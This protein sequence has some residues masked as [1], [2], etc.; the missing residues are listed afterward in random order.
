MADII[1]AVLKSTHHTTC[2]SIVFRPVTLRETRALALLSVNAA[3]LRAC[4]CYW[5]K[6]RLGREVLSG[7]AYPG[8]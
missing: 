5:E 6:L 2:G 8:V 7:S 3:L 4:S 1:Y